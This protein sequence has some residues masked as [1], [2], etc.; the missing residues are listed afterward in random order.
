METW[1]RVVIAGSTGLSVAC[2]WK[3]R[4]AGGWFFAGVTLAALASEY[5]DKFG[6]IRARVPEY[7]E[8]ATTVLNIASQIG[9]R[10]GEI[11]ERRNSAWD[12][13]ELPYV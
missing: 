8:R 4:R 12:G 2:F 10:L 13:E 11:A 3:R 1:K 7:M 9:Q 6:E 5:P